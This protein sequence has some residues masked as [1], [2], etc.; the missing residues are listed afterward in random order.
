MSNVTIP[1]RGYE[2]KRVADGHWI[3]VPRQPEWEA[4]QT[5]ILASW[6]A[7]IVS[8]VVVRFFLM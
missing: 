2:V 7:S 1:K 6:I 8:T 3:I 5:A 4:W